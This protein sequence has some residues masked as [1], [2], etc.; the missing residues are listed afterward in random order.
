MENSQTEINGAGVTLT[1]PPPADAA[2]SRKARLR[3]N[4]EKG[5]KT[6][7][8]NS[9]A[10][11]ATAAIAPAP[12]VIE[13]PVAE[14]PGVLA[15]SVQVRGALIE[16][17]DGTG[18]TWS[19]PANDDE[20]FTVFR[21]DY[22]LSH[23]PGYD[24]NF[25]YQFEHPPGTIAAEQA[26]DVTQMLADDWAV[27]TRE[28]LGIPTI[29]GVPVLPGQSPTTAFM[30]KGQVCIK[31]PK[32]RVDRKNAAFKRYADAV[33]KQIR[34]AKDSAMTKLENEPGGIVVDSIKSSTTFR[35]P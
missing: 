2:E 12:L 32:I 20:D 19:V 18:R 1:A 7:A 17:T 35:E 34:P 6:R 8:A 22:D 21:S 27:V 11:K 29:K 9:A 25:I 23:Y 28:E 10:R 3:A 13:I 33:V 14:P 16:I 24:P 15:K 31:T 4:L 30:V 5:R 26:G